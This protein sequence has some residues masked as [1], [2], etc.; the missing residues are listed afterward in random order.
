MKSG[1]DF[2]WHESASQSAY[3]P[4][5]VPPPP[6]CRGWIRQRNAR[7][8]GGRGGGARFSIIIWWALD[9]LVPII[10]RILT[11]AETPAKRKKLVN[12]AVSNVKSFNQ[13][14]VR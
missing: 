5:P 9:P 11:Q 10:L 13:L 12:L 14:P 8:G 3:L 1:Y 7:V 4:A 2:W 6:P